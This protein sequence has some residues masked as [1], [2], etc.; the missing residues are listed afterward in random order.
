[1]K[2][3]GPSFG[4]YFKSDLRI[5]L[6]MSVFGSVGSHERFRDPM[7]LKAGL[8]ALSI[9]WFG[10]AFS[11]VLAVFQTW[12]LPRLRF[13]SFLLT[14]LAT[15]VAYLGIVLAAIPLGVGGAAAISEHSPDSLLAAQYAVTLVLRPDIVGLAFATMVAIT[16]F[17]MVRKKLGPGV[18]ENWV[19]GKY[20]RPR[21]EE[22]VFMFLDI[23]DSTPLGEKLGDLQFSRLIQ[24][25]F[26]DITE[27]VLASKGE[28]SHYI[29]DE[30]VLT[31]KHD[32]GL[33]QGNVLKCY[34]GIR[35][36]IDARSAEY[37]EEFG[38]VPDFKAGA[39]L[40]RVVAT[41]VG[42]I[43]SEIVYHGDVLNTTARIQGL[44]S[45]AGEDFLVSAELARALGDQNTFEF[46]P[47]GMRELKG[48]EK[49][50][51]ICAVKRRQ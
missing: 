50:V 29:G 44:C 42:E 33:R 26:E 2:R 48:K 21:E 51:E 13:P 16:F 1:M 27:P 28:V 14:V 20:Y 5:S 37:Q 12:I 32:K 9:V 39:H 7:P 19:L 49:P 38:L 25:F 40:G 45:D 22:R 47:L 43:K 24:R 18:L 3:S 36:V 46:E 41:Q 23:K 11:L 35:D 15:S 6:V 4:T 17:F 30:A 10:L 34:F 31:W 8:I